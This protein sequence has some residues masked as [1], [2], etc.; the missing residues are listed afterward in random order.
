[1]ARQWLCLAVLLPSEAGMMISCYD[2]NVMFRRKAFATKLRKA[3]TDEDFKR[4]GGLRGDN[5]VFASVSFKITDHCT[6]PHVA[7]RAHTK[8]TLPKEYLVLIIIRYR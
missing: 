2:T 1:M 6:C 4:D 7:R 3:P 5:G 8:L